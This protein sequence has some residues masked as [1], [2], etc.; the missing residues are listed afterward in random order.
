MAPSSW[1]APGDVGYRWTSSGAT[2][3]PVINGS[4]S[5]AVG[6]SNNGLIVVGQAESAGGNYIAYKWTAATG[7][8]AITTSVGAASNSA[9]NAV[10]DGG[11]VVAGYTLV[12]GNG[13]PAVWTAATGWQPTAVSS[14]FGSANDITPNGRLV[15]G[16]DGGSS[17]IWDAVHGERYIKDILTAE[18]VNTGSLILGDAT[19]ISDD[20]TIIT[21]QTFSGG[22]TVPWVADI[23][24]PE[25]ASLAL[26]APAL[27][28][29]LRRT[30]RPC[31][32]A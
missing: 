21:G 2:L 32:P 8:V 26:L 12:G 22:A 1:A 16:G 20:G 28:P 14:S 15:V 13:S 31:Q 29:G 10:S 9:G 30:R 19:G 6:V 25:P 24:I 18:G 17:F 11:S 3:I 4:Y 7:T 23:A 5:P 27:L